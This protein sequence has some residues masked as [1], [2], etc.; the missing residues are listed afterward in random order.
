MSRANKLSNS[1]TIEAILL[2]SSDNYFT[3]KVIENYNHI[4]YNNCIISIAINPFKRR[5]SLWQL[6][7]LLEEYLSSA[8]GAN[9]IFCLAY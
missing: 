2:L 6:I 7:D 1:Q 3:F 5:G 4:A 8:I 9:A